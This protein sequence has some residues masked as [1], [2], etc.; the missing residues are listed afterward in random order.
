MLPRPLEQGTDALQCSSENHVTESN[1]MEALSLR[2]E[3]AL[4]S[5][6]LFFSLLELFGAKDG[7]E[8]GDVEEE[9]F[10]FGKQLSSF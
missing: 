3:D 2:D 6:R 9:L 7:D 8:D 1:F 4:C 5:K 10:C